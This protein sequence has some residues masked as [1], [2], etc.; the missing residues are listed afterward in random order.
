MERAGAKTA[1]DRF[2]TREEAASLLHAHARGLKEAAKLAK[3]EAQEM[4]SA[5]AIAAA[6]EEGLVLHTGGGGS[7]FVGV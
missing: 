4:T 3:A 2:E 7:G 5:Q 6:V 1:I